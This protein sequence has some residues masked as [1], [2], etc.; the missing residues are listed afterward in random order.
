MPVWH[1]SISVQGQ[2]GPL[3]QPRRCERA[4]VDILHGVGDPAREWWLYNPVARV[5]HLR[6]P[7]TAAESLLIPPGLV[8]TDAGETGPLRKRTQPHWKDGS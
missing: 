7:V 8:T 6:V 4:A 1:S 5:G 3:H 2:S